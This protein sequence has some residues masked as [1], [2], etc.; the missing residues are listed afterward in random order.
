MK[1]IE[2]DLTQGSVFK[3]LWSFTLPFIGANLLQTL[4]GMVD[5]YIVGRYA[6]TADVSA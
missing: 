1:K 6:E 5:L 4:Y 2:N 3:K